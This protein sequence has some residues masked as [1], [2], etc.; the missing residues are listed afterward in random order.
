MYFFYTQ[1]DG[2]NV[3][4]VTPRES[5]VFPATEYV[6]EVIVQTCTSRDIHAPVVLD[7]SHVNYID[8]TMAKVFVAAGLNCFTV[9]LRKSLCVWGGGQMK[10]CSKGVV[11]I[12][13]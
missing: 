10:I 5:L 1:V 2:E 8:S 12:S 4:L 13:D 11:L 9:R 6:R 3:L 7:G